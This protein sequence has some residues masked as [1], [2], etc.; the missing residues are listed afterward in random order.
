MEH[1]GTKAQRTKRRVEKLRVFVSLCS[2]NP[3]LLI[4]YLFVF[5]PLSVSGQRVSVTGVVLD[6]D[7]KK[8]VEFAS[9]LLKDNG[10]WAISGADGSFCI[11]DVPTGKTLLTIQSLGYATRTM[12]LDVEREIPRMRIL[13]H[14]ENLKLDEVTVT[15]KR[16]HDEATTSYTIDRTALE[17]QQLL[18]LGDIGVLL[19]GG[20]TVDPSLMND[21]RLALRS[22]SQ[23]K[24]N[25]AFGTAVEIDGIR[26]D[27]NAAGGETTGASTR[28]VSASNIESVEI[29]T[30]IPSVEYGDLSNGVVKVNTRKGK[31][32]FVV[33]GSINQH[34][35]QIA[36]NKGFDL[37]Q[38]RG[39]L[40]ASA[41]HA[42]SF[43]DAASPYTAYKRNILSLHYM[44]I[45]MQGSAP[46]TLNAGLTANIGGYNSEADPDN[47]LDDYS[48]MRDNA[49]RANIEL[50][51]LLNKPWL[52]NLTLRSSVSYS[53]RR[54]ENYTHASSTSTQ[55]YIHTTDLGYFMAHDYDE[56]AGSGSGALAMNSIIL[57]PTG[58]WHVLSYSDSKP[59]AWAA[60][61][62]AEQN[63]KIHLGQMLVRSHLMAGIEYTGS[64][65]LGR[66]T[67]Y[68]DMRYAPTWR[69]YRYDQLPATNNLAIFL[70][71]K[72]TIPTGRLSTLAV[73]AGLRS[74]ITMISQSD[75]GTVSSLS[76]RVN[77]RYVFWQQRRTR[78][79]TDLSLH[80]GWG[81]SV[82]LPSFQVLY[83]SPSYRDMLAFSSP[84][85]ADN[86]SFYAYYTH[87]SVALYNPSL[88]WQYTHQTDVG[89]EMS[90]KGTRLSL[91]A[92]HHRTYNS[93]MATR[94]YTPFAYLYTPPSALESVS[95]PLAERQ[96]AIDRQ[97]GVVTVSSADGTQ[98]ETLGGNERKTY[99]TNTRYV[100][101]SPVDR[102]GLEWIADFRQI[103][104]L[105]TSIRLDGNYYYYK[106]IDEV[107]F[108]DIP[109]SNA[110]MSDG[111]PYQY[112]GWYRG[113]SST[114]AGTLA[115]ASVSNGALSKQLNLNTTITTHIPKIRLIVALRLECSLYNYRRALSELSSGSR[116]I[117][118]ADKND[119]TGTPYGGSE[120][121]Y[122]AIYPEYYSTWGAPDEKLPFAETFLWAKD[123]DPTLYNDL[124][125]LVQKSNY[126]YVMNADRTSSYYSA[127]ISVTKE[128]GDHVSLSFYANNFFNN[129]KTVHSSQTG[130]DTSLF[131]SS[132]IPSYYY[133]LS[134]RL[135]L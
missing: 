22:G 19:P 135:K 82:K 88:K 42:S 96:Y 99:L 115:T 3:Y 9:I 36:L 44:N 107:L 101:A 2:V 47:E 64:K 72:L 117:S 67:Y 24:G 84:S 20:K 40:N 69:E 129:M 16:K 75:Y 121:Q 109:Q 78:W 11:K 52:T 30:G 120:N 33:E 92:F 86:T 14:Q 21:Q 28:T 35:R 25:A 93:Y 62:K 46:L 100:N 131:A 12:V 111:Q 104:A 97:T 18:N 102:Y 45:F 5:L 83:P 54:A 125:K 48:K 105:R 53:D 63:A 1:K 122:V 94:E 91:S 71:E 51:W 77:G 116:G 123:N 124:A 57:G 32:P 110:T 7:S 119:F 81:K 31:S 85:T 130:L 112:V 87:P 80:A 49:L 128:I 43:S 74:D 59:L 114:S 41:E 118:L 60:K 127:N 65:N 98:Q 8:P 66:G 38:G 108:A 113:S 106:G 17:Q 27:N 70:E 103:S 50:N 90:I 79:V 39:V 37:G 23:E 134:L 10:L 4:F 73:T 89:L 76:P 58:Y 34:T 56:L 126:A 15:A 55:P 95:S 132:Y 68:D 6:A 26:L 133:G 13:L 61:L 29:V